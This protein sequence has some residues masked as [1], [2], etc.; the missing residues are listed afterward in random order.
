MSIQQSVKIENTEFIRDMSNK[1]VLNTDAAGLSRYKEARRRA[2]Q[3]K[4]ESQD[5]KRRLELIEIEMATL[6]QII[7]ELTT[8]R[9]RG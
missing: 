8:L 3:E 6:K 2:L 9:S 7:G 4:K 5:T 1:A